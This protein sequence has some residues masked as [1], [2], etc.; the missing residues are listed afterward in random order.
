MENGPGIRARLT[1]QITDR[2]R[3]VEVYEI[4]WPGNELAVYFTNRWT[5]SPVLDDRG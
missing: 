2:Y 3:F 5:R 1:L 4:A